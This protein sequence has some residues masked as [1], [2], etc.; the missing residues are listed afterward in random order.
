[1]NLITLFN[2]SFINKY[3]QIVPIPMLEHRCQKG[4]CLVKICPL[5]VAF[6]RTIHS[7]QGQQAGEGNPIECIICNP[8]DRGFEGLNPG[9]L[10]TC[11]TRATTIGE[12]GKNNS[13]IYFEGSG[14]CRDRIT[15]M[16]YRLDGNK[17]AKIELRET[18][19]H[20]LQVQMDSNQKWKHNF[21]LRKKKQISTFFDQRRYNKSTLD[22]IITYNITNI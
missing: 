12:E 18:F 6:G 3:T 4:C 14:F 5:V 21:S 16:S 2:I 7:F 19:S 13:A 9:T 20:H 11:I 1:M 22:R 15:K 17:Y 10:T 8:G